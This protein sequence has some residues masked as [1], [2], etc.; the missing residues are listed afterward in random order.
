M[1]SPFEDLESAS[2]ATIEV[3][4]V[5]ISRVYCGVSRALPVRV[6]GNTYNGLPL[7]IGNLALLP[8]VS[9]KTSKSFQ[10]EYSLPVY[11]MREK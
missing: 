3:L 8:S 2:V 1:N 9:P 4:V 5:E 10:Q 11:R 6:V 7:I